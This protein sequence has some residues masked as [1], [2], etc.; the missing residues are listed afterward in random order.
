MLENARLFDETQRLLKETKQ[1][2]AELAIINSVGEAMSRQLDAQTIT[3]VVGDKMAEI[4]RADATSILLLDEKTNQIWPVFEL[5]EGIYIENVDPFPLGTGLTSHVIQTLQPLI[6]GNAEEAAAYGAYY[7]PK[8][9]EIN[10]K[11]TQSYLGVPIIVGEN[12]IGVV[13]VH[14]YSKNAY[15]QNSVRLLSTLANNMGVALEN[16]RLFDETNRLLQETKQRATE[17]EIINSISL[18]LTQK[19]ELQTMMDLVGDKLRETIGAPNIGIGFYVPERNELNVQYAYKDN[20]RVYPDPVQLSEFTVQGAK[21]GRSLVI[22]KN[23]EKIWPHLGSNLTLEGLIPRSV[24][25]V[26]ILAAKKLI[27]G[28]TVQDFE[29]EQAYSPSFVRLLET[30][31][32]NMGTAIRNAQLFDETQRLLKETEQR[33]A[34]LSAI[35]TVSQALVAESEL[36]NMIQLVGNQM[37]EIFDADIVYIALVDQ[38]TGMI[39]FPYSYGDDD[40]KPIKIGAGLTSKILEKGEPI[41]INR[42]ITEHT[43]QLGTTRIGKNALS[44]LGVPINVD[45]KPIGVVSVQ[46][47]TREGVFND[48]SLRLLSTIAANAGAAIHSA[49]LH[50]ETRRRAQETAALLDISR[51]ISSSLDAPTVL[52]GIATYA[53]NLLNGDLSAV[54]LPEE[55]GITFR[56]IAAVGDEVEAL[57]NDIIQ[58]GEGILG[59]IAQTKTGAIHNNVDQDPLAVEILGTNISKNEHLLAVPLLAG[60]DL[61]GLMSVWRTGAALSFSENEL[62]FLK[63]LARQ[64]VIAIQNAHL[65]AEAQETRAIAEQA[66]KAKS[67]FLANMSHE[68][69][70]P[71]NAIIGFTRIVRRKAEGSLPDRQ[72]ENLDKV[73]SSSEHLLGLINTVLDI[74]KIE[75]GRMDVIPSNFSIQA[76]A[77][78]CAALTIPLLKPNVAFEKQVDGY[79]GRVYSDQDKIKQIMLNLLSN[80]AKFTHD[81]KVVLSVSQHDE[82]HLNISVADNGIGISAEALSRIFDEFTQADASTT[83]QYGGTGLGLTISR[84]LAQLL[85]GE[86]TATSQPGKGSTFTLLIPMQYDSKT[87]RASEPASDPISRTIS[88]PL[89]VI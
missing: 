67:T 75:A 62:D 26:P 3:N 83:R 24:V 11:I 12:V 4:F 22:N 55:D 14:T 54:F 25:I 56:V 49:Q 6:L 42:N 15:D 23:A 9:A 64:A 59:H 85:G 70:T 66:N 72:I 38:Q 10:P 17:L 60:N 16:A 48:G 58:S 31:S 86:L 52:E 84:N 53:K 69:R 81:G 51:D 19:L 40:I 27:G 43:M 1:R 20:V 63:G 77:D 8:A 71:L 76:L 89:E 82:R 41:L 78:Q 46:S 47:T 57:R 37:R 13:S 33:A 80:A 7:P 88:R 29:K 74:A 73:L 45:G 5:D 65:F 18:A 36:Q 50:D 39:N 34:E 87:G 2:A 30:I 79:I 21:R 35:N 28:I 61:K 32:S 68:L 44:Y